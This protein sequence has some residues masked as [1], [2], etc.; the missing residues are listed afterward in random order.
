MNSV[1]DTMADGRERAN[2]G[3]GQ[4]LVDRKSKEVAQANGTFAGRRK[5]PS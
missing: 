5:T 4:V 3:C 1:E 2:A